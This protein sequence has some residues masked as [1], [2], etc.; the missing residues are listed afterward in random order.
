[1]T[2]FQGLLL[3]AG[4]SSRLGFPKQWVKFREKSLME[5]AIIQMLPFCQT[6]LIILGDLDEY[7]INQINELQKRYPS[8][9]FK[10]NTEW[11]EGMG[12]SLAFGFRNLSAD[13]PVIIH[14]VD[15]PMVQNIHFQAI[16][17]EYW[18]HPNYYIVSTH[19]GQSAPPCIIP[20]TK[21]SQF[22]DWEGQYGLGQYFRSNVEDCR[23]VELG[24]KFLDIDSPEDIKILGNQS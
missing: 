20:H 10:K 1:M 6:I 16:I 17:Q 3:A 14:L 18:S 13:L 24:I 19:G 22:Y 15:L 21:K 4:N 23:F 5:W 7:G 2:K 12:K 9:Q 8:I 11:K